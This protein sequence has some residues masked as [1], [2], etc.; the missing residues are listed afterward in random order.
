MCSS[1]VERCPVIKHIDSNGS[2]KD[3]GL[4]PNG[5]VVQW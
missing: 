4:I 3:N 5:C 2:L 1:V